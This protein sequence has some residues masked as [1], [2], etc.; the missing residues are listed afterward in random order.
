[1]TIDA[2]IKLNVCFIEFKQ[3]TL[4]LFGL[5]DEIYFYLVL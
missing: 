5:K 2:I 1:M 4:T 3:I